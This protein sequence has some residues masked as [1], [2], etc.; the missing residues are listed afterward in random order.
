MACVLYGGNLIERVGLG[1]EATLEICR[2]IFAGK[3][4][5]NIDEQDTRLP[6]ETFGLSWQFSH[7]GSQDDA[8]QGVADAR[9]CSM[10]RHSIS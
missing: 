3:V 1:Q 4:V 8:D 9:W 6:A 2:R 5:D 10:P 7:G